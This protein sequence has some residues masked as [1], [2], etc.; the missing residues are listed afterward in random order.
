VTKITPVLF[1]GTVDDF[2]NDVITIMTFDNEAHLGQFYT[3]YSEPDSGGTIKVSAD[4]FIV[5]SLLR[6]VGGLRSCMLQRKDKITPVKEWEI[7]SWCKTT[8]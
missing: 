5:A 4:R 7:D 8:L 6:I 1:A 3:K 2:N